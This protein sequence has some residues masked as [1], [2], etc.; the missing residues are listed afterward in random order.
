VPLTPCWHPASL[1][2]RALHQLRQ[3]RRAMCPPH[4]NSSI[5]ARAIQSRPEPVR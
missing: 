4:R 5:R 1:A 2:P 3:P